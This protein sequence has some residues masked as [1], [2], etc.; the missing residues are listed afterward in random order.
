[1]R[2]FSF[3]IVLAVLLSVTSRAATKSKPNDEENKPLPTIAQK[4]RGMQ[5]MPG[6]FNLYWDARS[7]KVWL[8]IARFDSEFL[9]VPSLAAGIG[10]NDIGLDRGEF[11]DLDDM[12]SPEH[13][14][15]FERVGPKVLLVEQNLAYR[16]ET[17]NPDEKRSVEEAFAQSILWGFKVEAEEK[18]RVLVDATPFLLNDAHGVADKLKEKKQGTYKVDDGRSAIYLP[19]TKNFPKN[20]EFEATLTLTGEPTGAWIRSVTPTPKAVTVRE[21]HSFVELPDDQYQPRA[22]DPRAGYFLTSYADYATPIQDPLVKRFIIRH[23]LRKKDPAAPLSDPVQPIVYYVDRG[24]PEPIRSALI[25]GASWWNQAFVAA[26]F[27]NAFQV[28]ELPEG[29]DPMDLRYNVIEWVH[30]STRGWSYGTSI[31]DPRTG[32]IIKGHVSLGS[33]RVRQDFLIAQGLVEAYANGGAPDPRLLELS[34]ARL[35][36]LAAHEVGHTL[37]LQHNF[38][39]STQNRASVMDYP[40]PLVSIDSKGEMDLSRAYATGIG[41][42]DKRTIIYGYREFPNRTAEAAGL[43]SILQENIAQGF[44][45]LTDADARPSGSANPFA[46]LW[47]SGDSATDELNRL[48]KVRALALNRLSE[49]N[50]PPGAPLATLENVLVPVYLMHRFQAE[51]ATKLVG[52]VNYTYAARGD[53]QTPDEPL[54][55]DQQRAALT[56]VLRTL[57]PDFLEMPAKLVALIPP[58]PPGFPR[59]RESFDSH[60]GMVFD[61]Q[62]AA[63][64]WINAELDLLLNPERLSRIVAQNAQ[65]ANGLSLNEL[66]DAILQTAAR[67]ANQ[68]GPQKEIARAV[69]KQFLNHLLQLALKRETE[70]QVT[71]YALRRITDLE[72]KWKAR[73]S[74]DPAEM[75]QNAYL[76]SQIDQFH[77]DPKALEIPKPPRIPDGSP[78]GADE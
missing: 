63:E 38:A 30:R 41:A 56:A 25:E 11:G 26:G 43:A 29:V 78:I 37:G 44:R 64:S 45:Y 60:D 20:T 40:P 16:A 49:K 17:K 42:W 47:D 74:S 35:R 2:S 67:T 12:I 10:S 18:G 6:Y 34:L 57:R 9:Y 77:R 5:A 33:L 70:P 23:R 8:E 13:L 65:T 51:A 61:P 53:G 66:F 27:K 19:F 55:P 68:T 54:A 4:T 15:K 24:A 69:E 22:F 31:I 58:P 72:A 7:G 71:A 39:A 59:D 46:H 73:S 76:L 36:Q 28:K 3:A 62:A 75:A 21:H 1:M 32:E 52:G 48:I 50:I 14:V